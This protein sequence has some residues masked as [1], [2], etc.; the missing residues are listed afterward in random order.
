MD[1]YDAI[2]EHLRQLQRQGISTL[3]ERLDRVMTDLDRSLEA[4][5]SALTDA[6]PTDAN[7]LFPLAEVENQLAELRPQSA[8]ATG[9]SLEQLRTLDAARSQSEL[10]RAMLPI[11]GEHVGRAAVL[12]I[13]EGVITAWNGTGFADGDRLRS[14]QGALSASPNIT[15]VV[16]SLAPV[17]CSPSDDPLLTE[18]LAGD[19]PQGQAVLLPISLR[20]KLMGIV[21]LDHRPGEPWDPSAAQALNA[22]TCLLIDTL[23]YRTTAPTPTLA[24]VL[25]DD[26]PEE[27]AA[28]PEVF[29][30]EPEEP[31]PVSVEVPEMEQEPVAVDTGFESTEEAIEPA[32]PSFEPAAAEAVEFEPA[33][34]SQPTGGEVEIDYDFEPEP[35]PTTDAEAFDPSATVRVEVEPETEPE[36]PAVPPSVEED[37]APPPVQPVVPPDEEQETVGVSAEDDAKHEE[38]RRFARLLVSEIKLY[39]EDEVERGRVERD[40]LTRL[41]ED[42][43]RSREMYEKRISPEVRGQ[44]D[45]FH[46]ELVRILADGDSGA[47]GE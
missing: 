31:E 37:I 22:V 8:Q 25:G 43:D 13:R 24:E 35:A 12:V 45:Y 34:E 33:A 10:L 36:P 20:G 2:L 9:I 26:L 5:K 40:I 46:D 32:V 41:K 44:R 1:S 3:A 47:L 39:N 29:S 38:A 27:P 21:Y 17:T 28:E 4:A 7:Q 42:I 18:W 15:R 30:S 6:V 23:K 16:D 19:E 11:L 14:W